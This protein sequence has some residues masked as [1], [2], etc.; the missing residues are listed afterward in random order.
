MIDKGTRFGGGV[1]DITLPT[2]YLND[3]EKYGFKLFKDATFQ[4]VINI[5]CLNII[6]G[7]IVN[8]FASL[9]D[10]RSTNEEDMLNV[11]YICDLDRLTLDS[12]TSAQHGFQG[13]IKKDHYLWA[14][15]FYI[16]YLSSKDASDYTG[17]ESYVKEK[18]DL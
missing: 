2:H 16:V 17:V 12:K 9:R 18:L 13:H 14:Y 3:V 11:C 15:V 10:E 5:I 6:F 4:I 8:S 1:G 7:I